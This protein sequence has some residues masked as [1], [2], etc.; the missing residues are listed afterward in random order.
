MSGST[1]VTEPLCEWA[2]FY[3]RRGLVT[4]SVMVV[5]DDETKVILCSE[6]RAAIPSGAASIKGRVGGAS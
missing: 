4:V 6:Q 2:S 5:V 3:C 1:P